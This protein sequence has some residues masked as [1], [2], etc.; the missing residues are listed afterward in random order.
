[1]MRACR[2]SV[3][4]YGQERIEIDQFAPWL[5]DEFQSVYVSQR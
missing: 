3:S 1:M 4:R 5:L 2:A